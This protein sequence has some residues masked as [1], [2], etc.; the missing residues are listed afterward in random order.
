MLNILLISLLMPLIK[1]AIK[2][3]R[4]DA[5]KRVVNKKL[6]L[7]LKKVTKKAGE[8]PSS[9]SIKQAYS[10]LDKA[11]KRGLIHKNTAARKKSSLAKKI[12]VRPAKSPK[13]KKKAGKTDK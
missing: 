4:Q 5:R 8:N 9:E 13:A 1:S 2:K 7:E 11:V 10:T 3:M 6:R 12:Q